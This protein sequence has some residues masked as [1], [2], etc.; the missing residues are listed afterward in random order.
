MIVH[1]NKYQYIILNTTK[2]PVKISFL[3]IHNLDRQASSRSSG[4]KAGISGYA[5][6]KNE[7][8][9]DLLRR[10]KEWRWLHQIFQVAEL[11]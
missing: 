1:V 3:R 7:L 4:M 5:N 6:K 2:F 10:K 8:F 11:S 9:L